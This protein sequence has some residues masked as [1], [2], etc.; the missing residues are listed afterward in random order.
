VCGVEL[1]MKGLAIDLSHAS[2]S[3]IELLLFGVWVQT[4]FPVR[5]VF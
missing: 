5:T 3:R 1:W 2:C 4:N